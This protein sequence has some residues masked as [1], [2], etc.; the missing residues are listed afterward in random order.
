MQKSPFY[1][2]WCKN[3]HVGSGKFLGH[4]N[5]LLTDLI[6]F[7]LSS[8]Y[9]ILIFLFSLNIDM[10]VFFL[11]L[12]GESLMI[13]CFL[14]NNVQFPSLGTKRRFLLVSFY[15]PHLLQL[16]CEQCVYAHT[17]PICVSVLLLCPRLECRFI[18]LKLNI[19]LSVLSSSVTLCQL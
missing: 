12:K 19:C 10:S 17:C 15:A 1:S 9:P 8:Y 2:S 18:V 14:Q 3:H 7:I 6:V 11:I 16:C 13:F 5:S 4:G